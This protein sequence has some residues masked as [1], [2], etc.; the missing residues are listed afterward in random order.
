[1]SLSPS[2]ASVLDRFTA[3]GSV[4]PIV[5]SESQTEKI[6]QV[7]FNHRVFFEELPEIAHPDIAFFAPREDSYKVEEVREIIT[8]AT[9]RSS[10]PYQVIIVSQ[11]DEMSKEAANALLKTFEDVPART[12]ILLTLESR[13]ALL[14][15]IASRVQFLEITDVARDISPDTRELA[16][17]LITLSKPAIAEYYATKTFKRDEAL[18]LLFAL[19][20][21]ARRRT[22][23]L[24]PDFFDILAKAIT[25]IASTNAITKYQIDRVILSLLRGKQSSP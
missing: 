15:T 20:D 23:E 10:G 18:E 24:P 14:E 1:M 3:G 13:E 17:G 8:R 12:L 6:I 9:I 19:Q 16:L 25:D 22:G 21:T 4:A 5:V 11:V 2:L 7:L